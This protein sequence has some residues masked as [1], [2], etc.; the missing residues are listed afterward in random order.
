MELVCAE[1]CGWGHYKMRATVTVYE[2]QAELDRWLADEQRKQEADRLLIA[3]HSTHVS[4]GLASG[5]GPLHVAAAVPAAP[6]EI[7]IGAAGTAAATWKSPE[8]Q[9]LETRY[10]YHST[11]RGTSTP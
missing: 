3:S 4:S 11:G 6:G 10:S 2:K 7:Q 9:P 8:N 1:L 5:V